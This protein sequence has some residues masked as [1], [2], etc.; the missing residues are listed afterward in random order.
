MLGSTAGAGDDFLVGVG[1]GTGQG[2]DVSYLFTA[3][4]LG[5]YVFS[6]C[7]QA[8]YD[9]VIEV[10]TASPLVSVG[11]NDDGLGCTTFPSLL[12]VTL[13]PVSD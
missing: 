10:F 12:T 11:F 6:T 7:N 5:S 1:R 3:P 13:E 8:S 4:I 2:A 9:T